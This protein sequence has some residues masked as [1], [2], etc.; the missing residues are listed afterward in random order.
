MAGPRR[1]SRRGAHRNT[2]G[3]LTETER[4][5]LAFLRA[6]NMPADLKTFASTAT[7]GPLIERASLVRKGGVVMYLAKEAP[8]YLKN[9][10]LT[11]QQIMEFAKANKIAA[12]KEADAATKTLGNF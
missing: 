1:A 8:G 9:T 10:A 11:F 2:T 4:A 12:P 5:R 6:S 7:S 3:S